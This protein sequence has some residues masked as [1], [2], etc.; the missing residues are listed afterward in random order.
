MI[1]TFVIFQTESGLSEL[2]AHPVRF[3][4]HDG[5]IESEICAEEGETQSGLNVKR[6]VI[7]LLQSAVHKDAGTTSHVEVCL[8]FFCFKIP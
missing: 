5:H 2:E 3:S 7:S 8:C 4:F 1:L 6:A